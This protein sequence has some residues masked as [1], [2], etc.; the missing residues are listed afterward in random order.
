MAIEI[1]ALLQILLEA[2]GA[3]S[4]MAIQHTLLT[5]IFDQ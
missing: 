4:P 5:Y 3:G 2:Y 1:L